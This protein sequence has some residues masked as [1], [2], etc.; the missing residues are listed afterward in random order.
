MVRVCVS[1]KEKKQEFKNLKILQY[2]HT[3]TD[4]NC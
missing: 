4:A 3:I 1:E 2:D